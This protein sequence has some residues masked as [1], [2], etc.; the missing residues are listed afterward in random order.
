MA[1][2]KPSLHPKQKTPP[3]EKV[4]SNPVLGY[5][6]LKRQDNQIQC[7]IPDWVVG[8]DSILDILGNPEY[9]LWFK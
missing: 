3:W 8:Q 1:A 7:T 9:G 6:R 2:L 4:E 5:N